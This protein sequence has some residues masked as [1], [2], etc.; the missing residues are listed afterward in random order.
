MLDFTEILDWMDSRAAILSG[1]GIEVEVIRSPISDNPSVRMDTTTNETIGRITGWANGE[2]F[3]EVVR[4][5]DEV[6]LIQEFVSARTLADVEAAY[7]GFQKAL[8]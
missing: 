2:F 8:T 7:A 5:S 6:D 1:D 4:V 3:F